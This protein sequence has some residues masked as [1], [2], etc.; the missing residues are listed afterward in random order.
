M[1]VRQ[2]MSW[3]RWPT[4]PP[5]GLGGQCDDIITL[6]CCKHSEGNVLWQGTHRPHTPHI[7]GKTLSVS[8]LPTPRE[9]EGRRSRLHI[10]SHLALRRESP[11]SCLLLHMTPVRGTPAFPRVSPLRVLKSNPQPPQHLLLWAHLLLSPGEVG[12]EWL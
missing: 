5:Q 12:S 9:T 3:R 6:S 2:Y 1:P 7:T 8:L 11:A 4:C 10:S